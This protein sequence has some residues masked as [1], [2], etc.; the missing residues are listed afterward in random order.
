[1]LGI[2]STERVHYRYSRTVRR[3]CR[4]ARV[5]RFASPTCSGVSDRRA[6][7]LKG[8]GPGHRGARQRINAS[9][10]THR[11]ARA[12]DPLLLG[13]SSAG[14]DLGVVPGPHESPRCLIPCVDHPVQ[15]LRG[16]PPDRLDYLPAAARVLQSLPG[17][18]AAVTGDGGDDR[19]LRAGYLR[20]AAAS[21]AVGCPRHGE[22]TDVKVSVNSASPSTDR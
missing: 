14:K 4:T 12:C 21:F 10:S 7:E 1:M 17:F 22:F 16:R 19:P 5:R 9:W 15:F 18:L 2:H 8:A 11:P 13:V 20:Q 3:G 6:E